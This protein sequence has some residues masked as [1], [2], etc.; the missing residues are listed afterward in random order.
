MEKCLEK[1]SHLTIAL[2]PARAD[3]IAF[4]AISS[5]VS[6]HGLASIMLPT[7]IQ[8][9]QE[10]IVAMSDRLAA[11]Q[12]QLLPTEV[13]AETGFWFGRARNYPI[14]SPTWFRYRGL[15]LLYL[16]AIASALALLAGWVSDSLS[17]KVVASSIAGALQLI[18]LYC[19]GP[20]LAVKVRTLRWP[21]RQELFGLCLV[22]L[23]GLVA[24]FGLDAGA[25]RLIELEY[26][27][28]PDTV[29]S[30]TFNA[31]PRNGADHAARRRVKP[32]PS[33]EDLSASFNSHAADV[34]A[35]QSD[36]D[37][38][39]VE[40]T[41]AEKRLAFWLEQTITLLVVTWL[42]GGF[43]LL[44]FLRQRR[45]LEQ[46]VRERELAE[47]RAARN[48]AEL[49]LSVLAAQVEPH[50]LFNTLAGVRSAIGSDPVRATAIVDHLVDYLRATIPQI[51]RDGGS[52]QARLA[53]QL[54]AARAYLALMRA[55]IPRLDYTVEVQPDL[56]EVSVPPLMLISLVENAVKHGVEPKIG[57]VRIELRAYREDGDDGAAIVLSVAD[58]G[59][60]FGGATSGSGIGLRNI[61]E[62][63]AAQYGDR[64]ALTLQ[65]GPA[66]GVIATIRLP[67]A[68]S[69][70]TE[71]P[72]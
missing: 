45:K 48:E 62:R 69:N 36:E 70:P 4:P 19:L 46:S 34:Q 10:A 24:S 15:A 22:L 44:A 20:W 2:V 60:G 47:A 63:L 51:R 68:E 29:F 71:L 55:R 30:A 38:A 72:G 49:R 31:G 27:E 65:A 28:K 39:E 58:N 43:D 50:F 53:A 64:A 37:A 52:S 5:Q 25:T 1:L 32:E 66:G 18:C 23:L 8:P 3:L 11:A 12:D 54:D 17:A 21:P 57:P 6:R 9:K 33:D 40:Q 13:S 16:V 56:G 14:F 35:E 7:S 41:D 67:L 59:V 61:R 26:P 42:A